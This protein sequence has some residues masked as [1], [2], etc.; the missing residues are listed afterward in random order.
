M[1]NEEN[2]TVFYF[3]NQADEII[4]ANFTGEIGWKELENFYK[5]IVRFYPHVAV[6]KILQDE[7]RATF[8][9]TE[10]VIGNSRELIKILTDQYARVKLA[11][12]QN[13]PVETAY[14]FLFFDQFQ[15]M[16]VDYHI[17]SSEENA[18]AWLH[19]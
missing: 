4:Y 8:P 14:S 17:F 18:V 5:E 12:V 3:F 6:L 10:Q 13:R 16:N 19:E 9:E 11:V 15:G 1:K 2:N 7:Q